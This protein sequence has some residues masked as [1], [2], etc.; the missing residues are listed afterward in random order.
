MVILFAYCLGLQVLGFL[1]ATPLAILALSRLFS[2][3]KYN[4]VMG[5]VISLLSTFIIYYIFASLF[6]LPLP[7]GMLF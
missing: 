5:V 3:K 7:D 6:H 4:W 1:P 2:Q